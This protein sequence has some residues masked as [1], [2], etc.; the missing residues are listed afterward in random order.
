MAE[1]V[2]AQERSLKGHRQLW[3]IGWVLLLLLVAYVFGQSYAGRTQ[4]ANDQREACRV[5]SF[6]RIDVGKALRAQSDYLNLVLEAESV[7]DD[8]KRAARR[9]QAVQDRVATRLERIARVPC[10]EQFRSP[11]VLPWGG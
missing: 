2:R 4:L 8:V 7:K 3:V 6:S 1:A 10:E 11:S 9:N 5:T